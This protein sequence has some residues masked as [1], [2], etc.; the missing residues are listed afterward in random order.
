MT[1]ASKHN[2]AGHL[3]GVD[4]NMSSQCSD[5]PT[6]TLQYMLAYHPVCFREYL[7]SGSACL[8]HE[9]GDLQPHI[10]LTGDF[11]RVF[12]SNSVPLFDMPF[13]PRMAGE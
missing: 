6:N 12:W 8:K 10:S 2:A 4:G 11:C 9:R 7:E 13:R 3:N 5:V 1:D